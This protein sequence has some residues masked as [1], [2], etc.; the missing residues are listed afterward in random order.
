VTV[1]YPNR[2]FL[3]MTNATVKPQLERIEE[4]IDQLSEMM[5]TNQI[6]EKKES[7]N[8]NGKSIEMTICNNTKKEMDEENA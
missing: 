4:K 6:K 5:E 8:K 1:I 7:E 3:G 2:N